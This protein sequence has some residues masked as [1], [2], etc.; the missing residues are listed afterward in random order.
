ML[1]S[2]HMKK[3]QEGI[4]IDIVGRLAT[5]KLARPA[6]RNAITLSMWRGLA[7]VFQRL[8]NDSDVRAIVLTGEGVD[9]SVGADIS[10]FAHVRADAQQAA[11][12]ERAVDACSEAIQSSRQ[13]TIAALQGYCLGG[14]C[15]LAMACDFR[16]GDR[17]AKIGIPAARLSIVYGVRSTQRLLAI[18][19]LP[20]AKRILFSAEN[21]L[22]DEARRVGF[23]DR[24]SDSSVDEANVLAESMIDNA[25][26]SIAG[27]K[28]ILNQLAFG[29]G[30]IDLDA[31]E[32]LIA[33]AAQSDDYREG[34]EAFAG[35]RKPNFRGF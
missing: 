18:V 30:T 9:F 21:L 24:L 10:E 15:H 12:Y 31:A 2:P 11:E 33:A 22:A 1:G 35:K 8:S 32:Q 19:G 17:T 29:R 7:D 3:A 16:V 20:S 26:L 5:I 13:P 23:L 34:R 25:P 27:S 14:A 6:H 4:E 28:H